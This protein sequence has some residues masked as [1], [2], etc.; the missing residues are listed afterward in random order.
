MR[1]WSLKRI[2]D[3]SFELFPDDIILLLIGPD[4][5]TELLENYL[6]N[7]E[8]TT[9]TEPPKRPIFSKINVKNTNPKERR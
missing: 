1:K 5:Y 4:R 9:E 3:A 7:S 6:E 2:V 8:L